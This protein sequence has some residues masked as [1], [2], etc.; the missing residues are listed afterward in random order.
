MAEDKGSSNLSDVA[1]TVHKTLTPFYDS[2][3]RQK[4]E[5]GKS[6]IDV[7]NKM[8][9]YGSELAKDLEPAEKEFF[10]GQLK[11]LISYAANKLVE[12]RS[13]IKTKK[14]NSEITP[15]EANVKSNFIAGL[16]REAG[17]AKR[18]LS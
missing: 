2:I 18:K 15:T 5:D 6:L 7:I 14:A 11:P 13:D 10:E 16:R 1:K 17:K 3:I 9:K 8:S 12:L 4:D